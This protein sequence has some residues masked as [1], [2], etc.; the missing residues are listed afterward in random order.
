VVVAGHIVGHTRAAV[1]DI[2]AAVAVDTAA[3]AGTLVAVVGIAAARI[4]AAAADTVA[5]AVVVAGT[6]LGY[7][8]RRGMMDRFLD[9]SGP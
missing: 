4:P 6:M 8:G 2:G 7:S 1:V 9:S 5:A 3:V